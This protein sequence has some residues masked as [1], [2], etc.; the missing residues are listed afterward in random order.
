MKRP[1]PTLVE[2]IQAK[3]AAPQVQ[4]QDI[5]NVIVAARRGLQTLSGADLVNVAASIANL[6]A[7]LAPAQAPAP[8]TPPAPP[9]E[10]AKA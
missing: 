10:P 3:Q 8:T 6:E 9:A 1:R 4:T 5:A 2:K 7:A